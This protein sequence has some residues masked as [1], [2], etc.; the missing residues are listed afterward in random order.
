MKQLKRENIKLN[1]QYIHYT[2]KSQNKKGRDDPYFLRKIKGHLTRLQNLLEKIETKRKEEPKTQEEKIKE[3]ERIG[4]LNLTSLSRTKHRLNL[5]KNE[6]AQLGLDMKTVS[7]INYNDLDP[8]DDKLRIYQEMVMIRIQELELQVSKGEEATKAFENGGYCI[9][10]C[11]LLA[12]FRMPGDT[13]EQHNG[14]CRLMMR[15]LE[16][17]VWYLVILVG[18]LLAGIVFQLGLLFISGK[19]LYIRMVEN[20]IVM[21]VI[22]VLAWVSSID[23]YYC[24][25]PIHRSADKN[26]RVETWIII[27]W[28][29]IIIHI[30]TSF[31]VLR[32]IENDYD[33]SM[34][35]LSRVMSEGVHDVMVK[36]T[37]KK[38]TIASASISPR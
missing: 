3:K 22:T 16:G 32:M 38:E 29:A 6:I 8:N 20:V 27:G 17:L 34:D 33:F 13:S 31:A 12:I 35:E 26:P 19:G 15:L 14:L 30:L 28:S 23:C 37:M 10:C 5:K 25:D 36:T 9:F 4:E 18:G 2:S 1:G 7:G 24:A 11:N 21:G